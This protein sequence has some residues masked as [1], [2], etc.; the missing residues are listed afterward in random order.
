MSGLPIVIKNVNDYTGEE[1]SALSLTAKLDGNTEVTNFNYLKLD[2][3]NTAIFKIEH[4]NFIFLQRILQ[5]FYQTE[6]ALRGIAI[7]KD[8]SRRKRL[9]LIVDDL[10]LLE[11]T[12]VLYEILLEAGIEVENAKEILDGVEEI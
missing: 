4:S 2:E 8:L 6:N 7:L 5:L 3:Y 11:N 9:T 12:K 1:D 10:D